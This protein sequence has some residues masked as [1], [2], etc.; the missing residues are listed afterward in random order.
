MFEVFIFEVCDLVITQ[1]P[2]SVF[3]STTFTWRRDHSPC[4]P[5]VLCTDVLLISKQSS[6]HGNLPASGACTVYI[7]CVVLHVSGC[8]IKNVETNPVTLGV[9]Y[10]SKYN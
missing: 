2:Q 5:V 4:A 10:F 1:D 7:G 8:A 3:V 6:L 9:L